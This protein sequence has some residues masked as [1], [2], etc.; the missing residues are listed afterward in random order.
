MILLPITIILLMSFAFFAVFKFKPM[1]AIAISISSV[2]TILLIVT[3]IFALSVAT[4]IITALSVIFVLYSLII[5][6]KEKTLF[7]SIKEFV[8]N[9]AFLVF[10]A[11]LA[12]Y[13]VMVYDNHVYSSDDF[14]YWGLASKAFLI[15][16]GF[17]VQYGIIKQG[18]TNAMPIFNA[19]ITFLSGYKE[20]YLF[21]GMWMVYWTFLLLPISSLKWNKWKTIAVYVFLVYSLLMF[22]SHYVRPNLY[23]DIMLAVISGGLVAYYYSDKNISKH[24]WVVI[25][26]GIIILPHIK[27]FTGLAFAYFV[28]ILYFLNNEK[29]GKIKSDKRKRIIFI[30]FALAPLTSHLLQSLIRPQYISAHTFTA[31]AHSWCWP[32]KSIAA[33]LVS[34][35]GVSLLV[36]I[37][38]LCVIILFAHRKRKKKLK[39]YLISAVSLLFLALLG[40]VYFKLDTGSK[41]LINAYIKNLAALTINEIYLY[42]IIGVLLVLNGLIYYIFIEEKY[43]KKYIRV[44]I[45]FILLGLIYCVGM[46][47]TYSRFSEAEALASASLNRYISSYVVFVLMAAIGV[48]SARGLFPEKKKKALAGIVLLYTVIAVTPA[49]LTLFGYEKGQL[50]YEQ[51][52]LYQNFLAAEHIKKNTEKGSSIYIID[53]GGNGTNR[54]YMQ[55]FSVTRLIANNDS[56][57]PSKYDGDKWSKDYSLGEW[58][59]YLS[60]RKYDYLYLANIDDYFIETYGS[61]FE[62]G[63]DI[64]TGKLYRIDYEGKIKFKL[65]G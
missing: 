52:G 2:I 26:L 37:A 39:L 48:M 59:E 53:Q 6:I 64:I 16:D 51:T 43:K 42:K 1:E 40:F 41:H 9:P 3:L 49:P 61:L 58:E 50:K 46:L 8:F 28:F 44:S 18:Q 10:M 25:L 17:K 29:L 7:I 47:A 19:F 12:V 54:L 65:I 34:Y 55:Y 30:V 45:A 62:T 32:G 14:S 38:A 63:N 36:L 23:N 5:L 33:A 35:I 22:T 13:S 21:I 20:S 57:G 4:Y 27:Y 15:N 11:L 24:I 31:A 60:S 56:L